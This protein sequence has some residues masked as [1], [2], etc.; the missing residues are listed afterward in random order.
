MMSNTSKK[1]TPK[2]TSD[3][4]LTAPL[5][6]PTNLPFRRDPAD[7]PTTADVRDAVDPTTDGRGDGP[8]GPM[9][10]PPTGTNSGI[11]DDRIRSGSGPDVRATVTDEPVSSTAPAAEEED[12]ALEAIRVSQNFGDDFGVVEVLLQVS[13]CKPGKAEW[14]RT[15]PDPAY[16]ASLPILELPNSD[17]FYLVDH[18]LCAVL[19]GEPCLS[20]RL[21]VPTLTTAGKLF[22]WPLRLPDADGRTNSWTESAQ[23]AAALARTT[24]IRLIPLQSES[25][26]KA[27]TSDYDLGEPKWSIIP[28]L[29]ELLRLAFADRR[30]TSLD[31]PKLMEIRQGVT[32]RRRPRSRGIPEGGAS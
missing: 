20:R 2:S 6:D 29:T 25:S 30:I 12:W 17:E 9:P 13:V 27:G 19:H 7:E 26:Y 21:L 1:W 32:G 3:S 28:P 5:P 31:H 22:L 23:K 11:G 4:R 15:H 8:E 24:W 14:I 10:P 18:K 16:W